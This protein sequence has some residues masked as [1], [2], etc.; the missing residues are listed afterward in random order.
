MSLHKNELTVPVFET[1][2][3]NLFSIIKQ[4]NQEDLSRKDTEF[5]ELNFQNKICMF[6]CLNYIIMLQNFVRL[7]HPKTCFRI[8]EDL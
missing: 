5:S 4:E 3:I 7:C 1:F 2:N 6:E 8:V